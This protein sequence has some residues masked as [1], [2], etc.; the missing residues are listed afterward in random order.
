MRLALTTLGDDINRNENFENLVI[1]KS[2]SYEI[3]PECGQDGSEPQT[4]VS[5]SDDR[6]ATQ[7]SPDQS[8]GSP[9]ADTKFC[10]HCG[11]QLPAVAKFC[12]SCGRKQM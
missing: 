7:E 8:P 5:S 4:A 11:Q 10:L 2:L 1:A 3:N 9:R 6:L 12:S